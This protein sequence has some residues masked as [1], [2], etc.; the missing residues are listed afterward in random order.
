MN[1]VSVVPGDSRIKPDDP[2]DLR[3]LYGTLAMV[4]NNGNYLSIQGIRPQMALLLIYTKLR[5]YEPCGE[6]QNIG[7]LVVTLLRKT[8]AT[9]IGPCSRRVGY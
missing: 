1:R 2:S 8:R 6:D 9:V 7:T 5:F 4:M 3:S